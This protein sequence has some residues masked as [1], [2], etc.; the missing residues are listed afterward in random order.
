MS[1]ADDL[2]KLNE[3]RFSGALSDAEFEKAKAA[4][5]GEAPAPNPRDEQLAAVLLENQLARIDREWETERQQYLIRNGY[6]FRQVPTTGV[7]IAAAVIGGG[8]GTLWT[9]VAIAMT[10]LAPNFGPFSVIKIVFPLFGVFF[11]V[12]GI[13][14]GVYIYRRAKL[15]E[16]RFRAYQARRAGVQPEQFR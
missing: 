1:L 10:S 9:I 2:N 16:E 7:G 8:F 13:V 5:L 6:G 14:M 11:T 3:L 15:Y 12:F 4:L